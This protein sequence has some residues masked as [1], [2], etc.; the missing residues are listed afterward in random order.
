[1]SNIREDIRQQVNQ[2]LKQGEKER[3]GVL[4][5]IS[6]EIGKYEIDKKTSITQDNFIALL[7]RLRKQHQASMDQ[8]KDA[9]RQDLYDI[10][11]AEKAIVESLLPEQ[12]SDEELD[13]L[14]SEAI[15]K[16]GA[17]SAQEMGK[18]MGLLKEQLFGKADLGQ[19]S[20]LIREK[21][22]S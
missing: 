11:V 12:L 19:V 2:C 10:E 21:L 5:M 3:L 15:T 4:R 20:K 9:G 14:V 17:Q 8:F 18:V 1:M 6:S 22:S 13:K 16:T 7:N